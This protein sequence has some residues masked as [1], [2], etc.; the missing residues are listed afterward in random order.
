MVPGVDRDKD[1]DRRRHRVETR[2]DGGRMCAATRGPRTGRAPRRAKP[3]GELPSSRP[4]RTIRSYAGHGSRRRQG[5]VEGI[6]VDTLARQGAARPTVTDVGPVVDDGVSSVGRSLRAGSGAPS[7][8]AARPSTPRARLGGG[9][10]LPVP[11]HVPRPAGGVSNL[12][13]QSGHLGG[14]R[15]GIRLRTAGAQPNQRSNGCWPTRG[16]SGRGDHPE[17]HREIGT[18]VDQHLTDRRHS[19]QVA[20]A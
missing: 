9:S 8:V 4:S 3:A 19:E 1:D 11:C 17:H 10:D 6:G 18:Q 5:L 20:R 2:A 16:S 14:H 7:T 13:P 12:L 15:I